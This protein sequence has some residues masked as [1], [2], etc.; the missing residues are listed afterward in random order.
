MFFFLSR[1][2][3]LLWV[4]SFTFAIIKKNFL[5][6][7][8]QIT[9]KISVQAISPLQ[10]WHGGD[11]GFATVFTPG[12]PVHFGHQCHY[13]KAWVLF[14]AVKKN[15]S[16]L[17]AIPKSSCATGMVYFFYSIH[18]SPSSIR[19]LNVTVVKHL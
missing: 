13:D 7:V 11:T 14:V 4:L 9:D 6:S 3:W 15:G 19:C 8:L 17:L 5:T 18:Y 12:T 1:T 2:I 10:V 16:N